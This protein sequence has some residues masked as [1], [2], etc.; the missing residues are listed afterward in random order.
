MPMS[1]VRAGVGAIRL[2]KKRENVEPFLFNGCDHPPTLFKSRVFLF[3]VNNKKRMV[4]MKSIILGLLL[5]VLLSAKTY[6]QISGNCGAYNEES[7]TYADN[8][9]WSYDEIS[10]KLTISGNGTMADFGP[11][12]VVGESFVYLKRIPWYQLDVEYVVVDGV[13]NVGARA[14]QNMPSIKEIKLS[15]AI[16][17]IGIGAFQSD[18]SLQS[19]N[20]PDR[21][22]EIMGSY[23]FNSIKSDAKIYCRDTSERKCSDFIEKGGIQEGQLS[24]YTF[25]GGRYY[26]GGVAYKSVGDMLNKIPVKRIYTLK[27]A[28]EAA[29]EVNRVS[30]RYR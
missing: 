12:E 14:F 30:I 10:K 17:Q 8:C 2:K 15:E 28:E 24:I 27:E 18:S 5:V 16:E 3:W 6:A 1:S 9:Q 23:M 13:S 19:I 26:F 29:R 11:N 21:V 25:D 4:E 22:S 20:I 7:R